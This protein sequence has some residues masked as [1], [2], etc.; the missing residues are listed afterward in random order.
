MMKVY[1]SLL[2]GEEGTK[3]PKWIGINNILSYLS[4]INMIMNEIIDTNNINLTS[5]QT[6][7]DNFED[8]IDTAYIKIRDLLVTNPDYNANSNSDKLTGIFLMRAG[9]MEIKQLH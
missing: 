7:I 6:Q 8:T 1:N 2:N 9:T 3:K 5:L 4:N